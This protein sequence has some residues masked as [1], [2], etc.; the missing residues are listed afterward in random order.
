[1]NFQLL[2]DFGKTPKSQC[3]SGF[4]NVILSIFLWHMSMVCCPVIGT[5]RPANNSTRPLSSISEKA[6]ITRPYFSHR[7]Q[8]LERADRWGCRGLTDSLDDRG[9]SDGRDVGSGSRGPGWEPAGRRSDQAVRNTPTN[10]RARPRRHRGQK[11]PIRLWQDGEQ[12]A[13]SVSRSS[14]SDQVTPRRPRPNSVVSAI[15]DLLLGSSLANT[16]DLCIC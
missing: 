7:F 13:D 11:S 5:L 16:T 14:P 3:W 15:Y 8:R 4:S 10:C 12:F 2:G 1:M 6:W 9:A